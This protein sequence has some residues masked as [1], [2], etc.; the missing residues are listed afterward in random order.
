MALTREMAQKVIDVVCADPRCVYHIKAGNVKLAGLPRSN[1]IGMA[2]VRHVVNSSGVGYFGTWGA[3]MTDGD[4][5]MLGTIGRG[6]D[7]ASQVIPDSW[8]KSGSFRN[9]SMW[10]RGIDNEHP[11][12]EALVCKGIAR[13]TV[14]ALNLANRNPDMQEFFTFTE[15][16]RVL[17][18]NHTATRAFTKDGGFYVL[19]WHATLNPENPM[20]SLKDD[21]LKGE[22]SV[23]F[24]DFKGFP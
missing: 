21:W 14:E 8:G 19:D 12:V 7:N 23:L 16:D 10:L 20:L 11:I 9:A 18:V 6:L 15:I 3:V 17:A 1:N 5:S 4:Y 2:V 13:A 24:K 22:G